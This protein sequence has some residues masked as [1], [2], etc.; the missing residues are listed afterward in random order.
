MLDQPPDVE[1]Q[2]D[3]VQR[4]HGVEHAQCPIPDEAHV[5]RDSGNP[6]RQ[7]ALLSESDQGRA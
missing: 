7:H 4:Q 1:R 2:E 6:H 3:K 5:R